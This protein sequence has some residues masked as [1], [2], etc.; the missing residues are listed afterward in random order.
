M[1]LTVAQ[2]LLSLPLVGTAADSPP[3]GPAELL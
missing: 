2:A 3:P 1:R